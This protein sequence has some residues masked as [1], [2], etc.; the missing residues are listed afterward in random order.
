MGYRSA[1][2]LSSLLFVHELSLLSDSLVLPFKPSRTDMQ[3]YMDT[4]A[5]TCMYV[6]SFLLLA[7]CS[8]NS[9][10]EKTS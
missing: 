8:K 5:H 3:T 7:I 10:N 6:H 2:V 9:S 4:N 1:I